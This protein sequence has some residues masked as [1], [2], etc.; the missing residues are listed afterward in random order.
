MS[1]SQL[2]AKYTEANEGLRA[3]ALK[4]RQN[5]I[6][7]EQVGWATAVMFCFAAAV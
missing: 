3:Q 7:L 4:N 5:E 2:F 6:I 1:V